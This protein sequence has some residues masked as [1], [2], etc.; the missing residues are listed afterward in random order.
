[1]STDPKDPLESLQDV[2]KLIDDSGVSKPVSTRQA[3]A[4]VFGTPASIPCPTWP[5]L[6]AKKIRAR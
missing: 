4:K 6:S 1:M 5:F 2:V 3:L